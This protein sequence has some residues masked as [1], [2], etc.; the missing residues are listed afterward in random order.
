[1]I[2]NQQPRSGTPVRDPICGMTITAGQ[3]FATRTIDGEPF[4]FCSERC[5]QQFDR[6]HATSATT[7]VSHLSTPGTLQRIELSVAHIDGSHGAQRLEEQ[8]GT[9]SGVRQ[10]TA[11]PNTNLLRVMYDPSSLQVRALVERISAIG[12]TV[13]TAT[14]QFDVQGMHCGSCVVILE[15]ALQQTP[16]VLS[17]TVNLATQQASVTYVPGLIDVEGLEHAVE[18]AGY[19]VRQQ[20]SQAVQPLS[21]PET[22]TMAET[23]IDR[24]EQGRAQEYQTLI[25]KFWFAALIS[26][27]VIVF[28]YPEFFPGLRNWLTP[29]SDVRRVVWGLLGLLTIPVLVWAGSH[30]FTGMWQAL[31]HRQANMHTLIAIGVSAAWLYSTVAVLVPQLFPKQSFAEV[32]YDVTAVVVALVNLG[33]ALELRARGRTSEAIK[34]L[35]GLQAKTARVVRDGV[36]QD[37]P[38][39]E[40]LVGDTIVVRPGEK[41]PVDGVVLNGTS[42]VDES[43]ITGES[44][45]VEKQTGDEVIG[46]TMNQTGSFRFRATK[47]GKDTALAQIIRLVQDAQG[48]KAPIQKVVDQVSH[49]F[50]PTV[51]I[52]AIAASVI[53]FIFGPQPSFIYALIVFVTTLII[54]CPCALG[55]ATPTSLTVGIGKGAE[56]G[57][58]IRSGDAIQMT[59]N[60]QVVVLDK[61]GTITKGKPELTNVVAQAG[62]DEDEVLRLAASVERTS[63]HPLAGA[64]LEGAKAQKLALAEIAN[65]KAIPGHGVV[66]DVEGHHVLLGNGKLMEISAVSPGRLAAESQR[67]ADDGKTPMYLAVDG[68]AAGIV[69]VADTVKEESVAAIAAL[70]RLGL[71]VVM[72]TGDNRRTADAIGRQVGVDRVIAEVLPQDKAHEVQKLQLEGKKVGMVGDGINDAPALTQADVGLAIG[73]GTDVAIEAADITL[74]SGS[75]GGVVTAIAIS[76]ATMRNVRQNLFGAFI[77]NGLGLPVAMG[78]LYPFT[79]ILLSPLIAAAAMAASSVTV[80]T[81]ANRLRNWHP[82]ETQQSQ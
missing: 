27:P 12:Y 23:T 7:G 78:L 20:L 80:V 30:F 62:F 35:I 48:S 60:L 63:E 71:Q 81:N 14:M 3:V 39:E 16:G 37:I 5:V 31:K 10:V 25:R 32:F 61:T 41:I 72:L 42:S 74:I 44:I 69:A 18:E 9:L 58:L 54:A 33:L 15:Q 79:G 43:M 70:K 40:V 68:Q 38:F 6:E 73:T 57:I 8:L 55:L 1:M 76:K 29:G 17:A 13:S 75:L 22:K 65:F 49:Y 21:R 66:A 36:E 59:R 56:Q 45:P 4:S 19:K 53:W 67:L 47:V 46:A 2:G 34:K 50:V 26:L 11:N 51:M 24:A 64:M 28:S 77:Y 82:K 52:L